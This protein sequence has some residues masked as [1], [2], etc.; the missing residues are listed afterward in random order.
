MV[1]VSV[2]ITTCFLPLVNAELFIF[3]LDNKQK[4]FLHLTEEP[5][6]R[7]WYSPIRHSMPDLTFGNCLPLALVASQILPNDEWLVKLDPLSKAPCLSWRTIDHQWYYIL[8]AIDDQNPTVKIWINHDEKVIAW[9]DSLIIAKNLAHRQ[10]RLWRLSSHQ[11]LQKNLK[12]WT[13][14]VGWQLMWQ[15]PNDYPILAESI[16]FGNIFESLSQLLN[17][18][19]SQSRVSDQGAKLTYIFDRQNKIVAIKESHKELK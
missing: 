8:R 1:I 5:D 2:F 19:N 16:F 4:E 15:S 10:N 11:S 9:S 6:T 14:L 18:I 12:K 13:D 3:T 17:Q 7:L